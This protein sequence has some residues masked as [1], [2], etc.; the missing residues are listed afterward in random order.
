MS[1]NTTGFSR[2]NFATDAER[3]AYYSQ[4]L[5]GKSTTGRKHIEDDL[6]MRSVKS[7]SLWYPDLI[8]CYVM[9]NNSGVK[10]SVQTKSGKRLSLQAIRDKRM[11]LMP[12]TSDTFLFIANNYFA[13][14]AIEFKK[15]AEAKQSSEQRRF[16][17]L[18]GISNYK[19]ALINNDNDFEGTI[20]QYMSN[21]D[22]LKL[23][24]IEAICKEFQKELDA[25]IQRK[26]QKMIGSKQ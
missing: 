26:L 15:D 5:K 17:S 4:G 7:F 20:K 9:V 25:K 2:H 23:K 19:Y 22:P 24:M 16:E 14:L 18:C 13:G 1:D 8:P 21:V 11:G 12:G 6:Q 10:H 3:V